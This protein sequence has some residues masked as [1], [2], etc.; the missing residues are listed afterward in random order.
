MKEMEMI[1]LIELICSCF[2]RIRDVHMWLMLV[3]MVLG[4]RKS[5]V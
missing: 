3:Y 4:D 5:V 2:S 1:V